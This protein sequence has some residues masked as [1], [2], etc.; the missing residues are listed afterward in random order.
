[1]FAVSIKICHAEGKKEEHTVNCTVTLTSFPGSP[2]FVR[3]RGEPGNEVS[4]TPTT[5]L[6]MALHFD[7]LLVQLDL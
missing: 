2:H 3:V 7:C 1:M 4:V 5:A 6:L